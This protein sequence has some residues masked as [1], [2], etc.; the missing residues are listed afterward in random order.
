M[1]PYKTCNHLTQR[2]QIVKHII[3]LSACPTER[4]QGEDNNESGRTLWK[5]TIA[6]NVAGALNQ[7]R[8]SQMESRDEETIGTKSRMKALW[9][10]HCKD[11]RLPTALRRLA[12]LFSL[13]SCL[14]Q[15][16]SNTPVTPCFSDTLRTQNVRAILTATATLTDRMLKIPRMYRHIEQTK[17]AERYIRVCTHIKTVQPLWRHLECTTGR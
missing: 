8:L 17:S 2:E 16:Y 4:E 5:S 7:S 3:T 11:V 6:C 12:L 1:K 13:P 15:P 14:F 10:A 9:K